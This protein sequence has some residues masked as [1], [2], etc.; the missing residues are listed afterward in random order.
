MCSLV[1][2]YLICR[3]VPRQLE[4]RLVRLKHASP[5]CF[6]LLVQRH[7]RT[8]TEQKFVVVLAGIKIQWGKK[9]EQKTHEIDYII[10]SISS[11]CG[12]SW[13]IQGF[14][15]FIVTPAQ[16]YTPCFGP[17]AAPPT[18][19]QQEAWGLKPASVPGFRPRCDPHSGLY[20]PHQCFGETC[21]CVNPATGE[22][23]PGSMYT[24]DPDKCGAGSA[25]AVPSGEEVS[26]SLYQLRLP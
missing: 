25:R 9:R 18:E 21:W 11:L 4:A 24:Y 22:E 26:Q 3:M 6:L 17:A 23:I 13:S 12:Q 16:I 15:N 19:C 5:F 2:H 8:K 1:F 20:W 7:S 10:W 14:K